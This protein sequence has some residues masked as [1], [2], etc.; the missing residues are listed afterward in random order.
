MGKKILIVSASLRG[1]S[2]SELLAEEILAGAREAGKEAELLSLKEK[3]L[4]FCIGCLACQKTGK[5]VLRDDMGK[6]LDRVREADV[7]VLV[8]PIYYYGLPGQ[9]KT[10]LDRC[11][12]LYGGENRFRDVYL[13]T[14]AADDAESAPHR[15][16][17]SLGGWIECFPQARLAGSLFCGG[18]NGPGEILTRPEYPARARALGASL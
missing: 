5:C 1:R 13:V 14:V 7:L 3:D 4:R 10:F 8:T 6:M 16:E 2:N 9:L 11:N 12:P 17:E 18:V 15:A